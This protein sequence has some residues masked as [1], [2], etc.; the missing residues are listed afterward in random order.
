MQEVLKGD[1]AE[2]VVLTT[3]RGKPSL[4]GWSQA[5]V[6]FCLINGGCGVG[7]SE[8]RGEKGEGSPSSNREKLQKQGRV[9]LVFTVL[10]RVPGTPA[11]LPPGHPKSSGQAR[12]RA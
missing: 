1:E 5:L 7:G 6:K 4:Q 11:V 8:R 10:Q 2:G 9:E 3:T 12:C